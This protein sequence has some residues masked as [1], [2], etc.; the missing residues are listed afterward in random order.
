LANLHP[1]KWVKQTTTEAGFTQFCPLQSPGAVQVLQIEGPLSFDRVEPLQ[2]LLKQMWEMGADKLIVDLTACPYVDSAGL[3]TLA[4]A[5][6]RAYRLNRSFL[7]VG[8]ST[9]I[10]NLL[11][12]TRLDQVFETRAS[13]ESALIN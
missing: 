12:L 6:R 7:L 11:R 2:D 10:R 9:Q 13:L 1:K 3:A 4:S 8:V 5:A